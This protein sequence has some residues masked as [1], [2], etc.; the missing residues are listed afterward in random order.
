VAHNVVY[1]VTHPGQPSEAP[2][3]LCA[4]DL[5]TGEVRARFPIG[6]RWMSDPAVAAGVVYLGVYQGS[7]PRTA[8]LAAIEAATGA[9]LWRV[10]VPSWFSLAPVVADGR[11]Y[12]SCD[13]GYLYAI[14][15]GESGAAPTAGDPI[16]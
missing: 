15:A 8:T 1:A 16:G 12:V 2:D 6:G 11:V 14:G 9:E 10:A 3:V 7:D 4:L 13:D 5:A